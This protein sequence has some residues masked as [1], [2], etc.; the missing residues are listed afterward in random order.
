MGTRKKI[1]ANQ[2]DN[3]L[4]LLFEWDLCLFIYE[5]FA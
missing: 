4:L 3:D 1:T 2:S 5:H